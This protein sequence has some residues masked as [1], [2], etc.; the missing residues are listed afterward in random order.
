MEILK[1]LIITMA[2]VAAAGMIAASYIAILIRK[3]RRIKEM[4]AWAEKE[5][6]DQGRSE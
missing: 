1:V 6:H 3:E 4:V 5:L 2:I